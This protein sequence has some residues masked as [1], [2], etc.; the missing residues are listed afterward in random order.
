[1]ADDNVDRKSRGRRGGGRPVRWVSC[2]AVGLMA[3]CLSAAC[4]SSASQATNSAPPAAGQPTMYRTGGSIGSA[5]KDPSSRSAALQYAECMRSHGV[6]NFPDPNNQGGFQIEPGA[7]FN[8]SSPQYSSANQ[9]CQHYL[10]GEPGGG[11]TVI[12]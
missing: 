5:G 12:G 3:T 4:A 6:K 7:G 11:Q 10:S 1:M 8:P 9:A 2:L